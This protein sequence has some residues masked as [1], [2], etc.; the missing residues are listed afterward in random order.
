M[1]VVGGA[2]THNRSEL[3]ERKEKEKKR[4]KKLK[5]KK[6]ERDLITFF[7]VQEILPLLFEHNKTQFQGLAQ[8]IIYFVTHKP[9]RYLTCL[10]RTST[11]YKQT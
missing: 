7:H 6:R 4:K 2:Q 9:S 3:K 10:C 8:F 11:S 5:K 1:V